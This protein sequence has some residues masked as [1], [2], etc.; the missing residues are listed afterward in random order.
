MSSGPV[1]TPSKVPPP[2]PVELAMY[3]AVAARRTQF[4]NL[5]WQVPILSITAQAFLFTVSLGAD[6]SQTARIIAASL[7]LITTILTL[8]LFVRHRQS[9][10]ADAHWLEDY[11]QRFNGESFHG[12]SWQAKRNATSPAAQPFSPLARV[13][14]FRTWSAGLALFG[15]V[16]IIILFMAVAVPATLK[17]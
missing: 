14:G 16:S 2:S 17:G 15:L 11:E 3:A 4:D 7:S 8:Q 5:M 9:E 12:V 1:G 10:I 6:T 13:G